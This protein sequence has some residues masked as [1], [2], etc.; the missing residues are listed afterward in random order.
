MNRWLFTGALSGALLCA[1]ILAAAPVLAQADNDTPDA[2]VVLEL[3]EEVS[4]TTEGAGTWWLNPCDPDMT[5]PDIVLAGDTSIW[6]END[7]EYEEYGFASV[8]DLCDGDM[9]ALDIMPHEIG[10]IFLRNAAQ[11]YE[12]YLVYGLG[13]A[14]MV[15]SMESIFNEWG[16][17]ELDEEGQPVDAETTPFLD[18]PGNYD[19]QYFV[20]DSSGNVGWAERRV[21]IAGDPSIA[22]IGDEVMTYECYNDPPPAEAFVDPG[23]EA[24]DVDGTPIVDI[25]VDDDGFDEGVVGEYMFTYTAVTADEVELTV[26]RTVIVEDTTEPGL[27]ITG[28]SEQ[29]VL[30]NDPDWALPSAFSI[31]ACDG[32]LSANV[33][34]AGDED[35]DI[36]MLG[37]TFEVTYSVEDSSGNVAERVLTLSVVGDPVIE[38]DGFA[39]EDENPELEV[40]CGDDAFDA[41]ALATAWDACGNDITA[42]LDVDVVLVGDPDKVDTSVPE[43][44]YLVTYTVMDSAGTE[45]QRTLTVVIVDYEPVIT[46]EEDEITVRC[47]VAIDYPNYSAVDPC[48]GDAITGDDLQRVI[49]VGFSSTDPRGGTYEVIIRA[50]GAAGNIAEAPLIVNVED[51][52]FSITGVPATL[53]AECGVPFALPEAVLVGSC[54][55]GD[56]VEED[57]DIPEALDLEDPAVGVYEVVYTA[58]DGFNDA[59][60]T[61]TVTVTDTQAP[62]VS[63][64]GDDPDAWDPVNN[65]WVYTVTAGD[66]AT[67]AEFAASIIAEDPDGIV[68]VADDV[69]DGVFTSLDSPDS[70]V[71]LVQVSETF[72]PADLEELG[73]FGLEQTLDWLDEPALYTVMYRGQDS[74]GNNSRERDTEG[75]LT[76]RAIVVQPPV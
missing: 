26:T 68:G 16:G 71:I 44:E 58:T 14:E 72:D 55:L 23:A 65:A 59:E 30:C 61:L 52:M 43:A 20:A 47:G 39:L 8:I 74:S 48:T 3:G 12:T 50:T 17:A 57:V 24:F 27:I 4:G 29:S 6:L 31:D 22:L 34:T 21:T 38:I 40:S 15:A 11:I 7:D 46:L 67:W 49:P 1:L 56:F 13:G 69:C 28:G 76:I 54:D 45:V 32:N 73:A 9:L 60:H 35:I 53:T 10:V 18:E 63:V 41:A 75:E 25:D 36:S 37:A 33:E 5:P 64:T 51:P 66:H 2:A 19:I 42:G 62:S 70:F